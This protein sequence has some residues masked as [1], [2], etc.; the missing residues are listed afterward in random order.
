MRTT[1]YEENG[2]TLTEV[3][4]SE[5]AYDYYENRFGHE[6]EIRRENGTTERFKVIELLKEV[7]I[8]SVLNIEVRSAEG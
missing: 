3:E 2:R 1:S 4:F 7:R 8:R 5:R 6:G